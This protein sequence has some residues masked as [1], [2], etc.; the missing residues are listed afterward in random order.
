M[1]NTIAGERGRWN[2][3]KRDRLGTPKMIAGYKKE[4]Y[5]FSVIEIKN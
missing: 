5:S 3:D 2:S 4:C 1:A